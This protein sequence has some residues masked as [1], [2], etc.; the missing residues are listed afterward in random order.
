MS[1]KL[2]GHHLL[3]L[4]GYRGMGY[5]EEFA[6]NMTEVYKQLQQ[7]AASLVA[8]VSGPDDLCQSFPCE[9]MNHCDNRQVHEKDQL[10]IEHLGLKVG[11]SLPWQEVVERIRV[12]ITPQ[13]IPQWCATCPWLKYGVCEEGVDRI[14][15]GETLRVL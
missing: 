4:L 5:S 8:V 11:D 6:A 12:N 9:Q 1:I 10:V 15:K 13:H 7:D 3:C 14:V 2:R